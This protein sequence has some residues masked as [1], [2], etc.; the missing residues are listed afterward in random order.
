M[1]KYRYRIL[2][3][4]KMKREA[5]GF[6]ETVYYAITEADVDCPIAVDSASFGVDD[7]K[8]YLSLYGKIDGRTVYHVECGDLGECPVEQTVQ[9]VCRGGW[10]FTFDGDKPLSVKLDKQSKKA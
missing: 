2:E 3:L 1:S 8:W 9:R 10:Q 6:M 5:F 7:H 4:D